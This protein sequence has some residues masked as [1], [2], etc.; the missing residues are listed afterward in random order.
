MFLIFFSICCILKLL[1]PKPLAMK[2]IV[3][4]S[5]VIALMIPAC[6]QESKSPEEGAWQLVYAKNR[7]MEEAFPAD[8]PG[9]QIKMF[10]DGRISWVGQFE[11]PGDTAIYYD[12]GVGTYSLDG[13]N[14][15]E[16]IIIHASEGSVGT[17]HMIIEIRNDSLLQM[18]PADENFK[19]ADKHHTFI[20]TRVK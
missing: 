17:K 20:Y 10:A 12:Y 8:I 19:L 14:F 4:F 18:W 3:L 1:T 9:E 5:F 13:T 7:N 11:L 2:Q 15:T 16:N 6:T